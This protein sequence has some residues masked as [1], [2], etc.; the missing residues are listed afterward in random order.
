LDDGD[1]ETV[2][3]LTSELQD[4]ARQ[5]SQRSTRH[6]GNANLGNKAT[7]KNPEDLKLIGPRVKR[8]KGSSKRMGR[9]RLIHHL[10]LHKGSSTKL[11]T[12]QAKNKAGNAKAQQQ[13]AKPIETKRHPR[14]AS[15]PANAVYSNRDRKGKTQNTIHISHTEEL[16]DKTRDQREPRKIGSQDR[17]QITKPRHKISGHIQQN[18]IIKKKAQ[19]NPT[20]SRMGGSR[21][22]AKRSGGNRIK[23]VGPRIGG[24]RKTSSAEAIETIT[25]DDEDTTYPNKRK[26]TRRSHVIECEPGP[27]QR[28]R[29]TYQINK[30]TIVVD[31]LPFTTSSPWKAA[32]RS[33]GKMPLRPPG[34]YDPSEDSLTTRERG[35]MKKEMR[36]QKTI[37]DLRSWFHEISTRCSYLYSPFTP[38]EENLCSEVNGFIGQHKGYHSNLPPI[39][40]K[41]DWHK[42]VNLINTFGR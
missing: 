6:Q 16:V 38:F 27:S 34:T 8:Q 21:L 29:T 17:G 35:A 28:R 5:L 37:Q 9:S 32:P 15:Q 18:E 25:I 22:K 40:G 7:P 39:G 19:I 10:R 36:G 2:D 3:A 12:L 26:R 11:S 42:T 14:N 31:L 13:P 30:E 1:E 41:T 20:T 23:E 24:Q 33:A 4:A